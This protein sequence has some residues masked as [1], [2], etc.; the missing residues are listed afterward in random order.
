MKNDIN[1][2]IK[3]FARMCIIAVIPVLIISIEKQDFD[4]K[5]TGIAF[6]LAILR[7]VDSYIHESKTGILKNLNGI[8][9]I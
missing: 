3:E 1:E 4:Y 5:S 8:S 6:A 9:P 2:S 7:A